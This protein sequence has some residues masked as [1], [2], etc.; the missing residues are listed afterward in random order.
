MCIRDR[1][2][3]GTK[4]VNSKHKVILDWPR[5]KKIT[6]NGWYPSYRF[7]Q[8]DLE[9]KLRK[10]LKNYKKVSIEQYSEVIK[11]KNSKNHV[12]ITYLNTNNHKEYFVYEILFVIICI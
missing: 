8:P 4:F 9:K 7:H 2:N 1:I 11:I 12:D 5:P 6:D 3:R 10:K